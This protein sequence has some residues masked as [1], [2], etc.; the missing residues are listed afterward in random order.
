M[1]LPP[2][3]LFLLIIL[4]VFGCLLGSILPVC[5]PL[6]ERGR[7]LFPGATGYGRGNRL[8]VDE[9]LFEVERIGIE[10]QAVEPDLVLRRDLLL[11]LR[12][13][14]R[15][16]RRRVRCCAIGDRD[17]LLGLELDSVIPIDRPHDPEL[18]CDVRFDCEAGEERDLVERD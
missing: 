18:V 17:R 13:P 8:G 6:V 10:G 12:S 1:G 16:G 7:K 3:L 11:A 2:N 14:G 5:P 15:A 4:L 9:R